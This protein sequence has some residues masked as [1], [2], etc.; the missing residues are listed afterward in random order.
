[1][2]KYIN[3]IKTLYWFWRLTRRCVDDNK[4][5]LEIGEYPQGNPKGKKWLSLHTPDSFMGG[6]Y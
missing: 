5:V 3:R 6:N 2:K 4:W 1:M